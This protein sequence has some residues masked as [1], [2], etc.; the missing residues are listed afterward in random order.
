MLTEKK[1]LCMRFNPLT[2]CKVFRVVLFNVLDLF[3]DTLSFLL[4]CYHVIIQ[5]KSELALF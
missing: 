3:T 2:K 5:V 1:V 4:C